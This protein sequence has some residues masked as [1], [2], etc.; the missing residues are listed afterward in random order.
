[1]VDDIHDQDTE[2]SYGDLRVRLDRGVVRPD[3]WQEV[4]SKVA[5]LDLDRLSFPL[6]LR[7]WQQADCFTPLGMS[8]TK[9]VSDLLIDRKVPVIK[10]KET[11]VLVSG[12]EIAWVVGHQMSDRFK[13]T[14]QTRRLIKITVSLS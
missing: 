10:K 4:P 2:V 12:K 11:L 14:P 13:V 7:G 3:R 6:H 8:G 1:M 9:K 5:Y